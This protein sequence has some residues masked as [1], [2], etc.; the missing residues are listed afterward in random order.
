MNH[1]PQNISLEDQLKAIICKDPTLTQAYEN[2][3]RLH[4]S[5]SRFLDAIGMFREGLSIDPAHAGLYHHL[6]DSLKAEGRL[7][8]AVTAYQM[9]L[10]LDTHDYIALANVG[11]VYKHLG[12]YAQAEKC[13]KKTLAIEPH[14]KI[15]LYNLGI[16][17]E[18]MWEFKKAY[19]CFDKAIL[20]D[21]QF[22]EPYRNKYLVSRQLCDFEK[23]EEC[24]PDLDRLGADDPFMSI[25]RS[26]NFEKNLDVARRWSAELS[27]HV[28]KHSFS[29]AKRNPSDTIHIGYLSNDFRTHPIGMMTAPLFKLHNRKRFKVSAYSYGEDDHSVYRKTV[30]ETAD[31]FVDIRN[32]GVFESAQRINA[33][34]VDI[35]IDVT[36]YTENHRLEI[37]AMRPAQ[38]QITW[39]GFPG[40]L[41]A[42]F[43]DY[44]IADKTII[45]P[46]T[47]QW[48]AEK[49]L[50]LP[51]CYQINDSTSLEVHSSVT[52]KECGLKDDV[53]VFASFNQSY[54]IDPL[55]WK[56]WMHILKKTPH[57]VLCLWQ[58]APETSQNLI[59]SAQKMGIHHDRLLFWESLPKE[60]HLARIRL[61]DLALD[62][63]VYGGHTTTTDCLRMGVPVITK[64]GNHFA[65]RVCAS[66]LHEVGLDELVVNSLEEYENLAIKLAHNPTSLKQFRKALNQNS[67]RKTLFNTKRFVTSLEKL[68]EDCIR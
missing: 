28:P 18:Q 62:T 45:P 30:Q 52:R 34:G 14:Q 31:H 35:L 46:E 32:M 48:F 63:R 36:G 59:A 1:S 61:V 44:I 47:E 7:Q 50:T 15:A 39:L 55:M 53:F 2:L 10:C 41:G 57:S 19:E 33:D 58:Q 67:L 56:S 40:S 66:I 6:G 68:Y 51:H 13:L 5:E 38:I 26:E 27:A 16:V 24:E 21:P 4:L 29:Y 49:V 65:S 22:A 43:V 42:D 17:Y 64:I 20:V 25:I 11:A 12:A 23:C 3:G 8:E 37:M 60:E 54:K 9:A